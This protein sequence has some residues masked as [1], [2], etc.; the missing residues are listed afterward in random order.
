MS[1][2]CDFD[3]MGDR[4]SVVTFEGTVQLLFLTDGWADGPREVVANRFASRATAA[5]LRAIADHLEALPWADDMSVAGSVAR[6]GV[7]A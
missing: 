7:R 3:L 2:G 4:V 6:V 1:R 5:E